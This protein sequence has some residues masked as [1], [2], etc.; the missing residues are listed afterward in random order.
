MV[1][2]IIEIES[3]GN[4]HDSE[5][6]LILHIKMCDKCRSWKWCAEAKRLF[7]IDAQ[8]NRRQNNGE[9]ASG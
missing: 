9:S 4:R 6:Q 1:R 7:A 3:Q 2:T 5:Y 8:S